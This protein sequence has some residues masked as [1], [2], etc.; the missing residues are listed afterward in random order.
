MAT[1]I[2]FTR[3]TQPTVLG[4]FPLVCTSEFLLELVFGDLPLCGLGAVL[5]YTYGHDVFTQIL[6][7]RDIVEHEE[8][9]NNSKTLFLERVRGTATTPE[10]I[11]VDANLNKCILL[12]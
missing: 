4:L 3:I 7:A 6:M 2:Y 1:G 5:L 11:S 12:R 9:I 10:G 8:S